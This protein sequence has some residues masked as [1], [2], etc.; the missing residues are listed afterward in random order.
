MDLSSAIEEYI[1]RKRSMGFRYENNSKELRAFDRMYSMVPLA[2][3]RVRH[4]RKFLDRPLNSRAT[5]IGRY[6][7]FRAFFSYWRARQ[8]IDRIPMPRERRPGKQIF[9]PYIFTKRQIA[10]LLTGT[11]VL[12]RSTLSAVSPEAFRALLITILATGIWPGEAL[13]LLQRDVNWDSGTIDLK[14]R[15]G[16]GR[17]IPI[18]TDLMRLLKQSIRANPASTKYVFATKTG[19]IILPRRVAICFRR[20]LNRAGIKSQ[21]ASKRQ[22]GL[23]DLRHTFA[24]NR[25]TDWERNRRDLDL[26]LP[27]LAVYMGLWT[28]SVTERYLPL[29]PTHFR[30]QT[31]MLS[32]AQIERGKNQKVS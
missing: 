8:K 10:A 19:G 4:V 16:T 7:R 6:V 13:E 14:S 22:P 2:A 27:R 24:V 30:E 3:I 17:K 29:A 28:F 31:R 15:F 1:G 25:I 12:N 23:R 5:W 20:V 21:D 32:L 11:N 9:S 26:M 18:G